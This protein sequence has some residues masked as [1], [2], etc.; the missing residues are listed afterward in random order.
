M[1]TTIAVILVAL[2][3]VSGCGRKSSPK[4]MQNPVGTL[5]KI[6]SGAA[7]VARKATKTADETAQMATQTVDD[8]TLLVKVTGALAKEKAL[9][10]CEIVA[11][12]ESGVVTLTGEVPESALRVKAARTVLRVSRV[13]RVKNAIVLTP[14][15]TPEADD[16]N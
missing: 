8:I 5:E 6:T 7:D 1:R 2:L 11:T 15:E 14:K 4:P 16:N 10:D 9:A 12:C 13:K 3:L